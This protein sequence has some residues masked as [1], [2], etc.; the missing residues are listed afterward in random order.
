MA[1]P[2]VAGAIAL[3]LQ[4]DPALIG[5]Q[6]SVE[7][8]LNATATD[9]KTTQT[10]GSVPGNFIPNNTYGWGRL[11]ILAAVSGIV[12]KSGTLYNDETWISDHVYVIDGDLTVSSGVTLT[13]NAGTVV[14]L[15]NSGSELIIDGNLSA[16]GTSGQKVYFTS[17]KDDS[18]GGDTNGD[19]A[20][21]TPTPGDWN[22]IY[23][24]SGSSGTLVHTEFRYGGDSYYKY[25]MLHTEGASVT[26]NDGAF[27]D[28]EYSAVS[29][30]AGNEV[31]LANMS[32]SDFYD[33]MF[34]G[35]GFA[36]AHLTAVLFGMRQKLLMCY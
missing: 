1:A 12:Y 18:V 19:G 33:S 2:H 36:A 9:K 25:G 14:K 17:Y 35:L 34:N 7:N 13:I 15:L 24:R 31:T 32:S 20:G 4:H 30:D 26:V 3:L 8:I 10:C 28:S 23:Y 16:N 22:R 5:D 27:V 11:D 29:S 6:V 21:S